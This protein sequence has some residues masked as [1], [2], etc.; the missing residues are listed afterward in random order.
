M[1]S[2]DDIRS[3][4]AEYRSELDDIDQ[5]YETSRD[6]NIAFERLKRW[7]DRCLDW[8]AVNVSE[9]EKER[10]AEK[11]GPSAVS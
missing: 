1:A 9:A 8:L 10:L 11:H 7:K 3:V 2:S 4:I 6:Y 5:K